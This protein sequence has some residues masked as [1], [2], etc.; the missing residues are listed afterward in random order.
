MSTIERIIE[1]M[2]KNNI[3][4]AELERMLGLKPKIVY[5]WKTGRSKS[6]MDF[7]PQLSQI[8]N[9]SSEYLLCI[10]DNQSSITNY[11]RNMFWER[12]LTE[13]EKVGKKPNPVAKEL[14]ISSGTVTGWKNGSTP[15][16]RALELL[17]KYFN[18]S[19]DYLLGRVDNPIPKNYNENPSLNNNTIKILGRD[20]TNIEKTLTDDEI[21]VFKKLISSLPDAEDL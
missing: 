2:K 17:S 16:S 14:G 19:V 20:G 18:C 13:C 4:D 5:G 21:E 3:K 15:N 11:T 7:I 9:V 12:F 1:L 8:F 10:S 6:Y